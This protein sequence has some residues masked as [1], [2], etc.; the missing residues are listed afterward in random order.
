MM[1]NEDGASG[2]AS[3]APLPDSEIWMV[4]AGQRGVYADRFLDES[5]VA[6]GW[7]EIGEICADGSD[8]EIR[9]RFA[10]AF[11]NEKPGARAA[12]AGSVRRFVKEVRIGDEVVTYG[13]E[14]RLYRLGEIRS[15]VER[16]LIKVDG[17]ER[18]EFQRGVEWKS[19]VLRDSLLLDTRNRLGGLLTVF[20]V[21]TAA[22]VDLRRLSSQASGES[23]GATQDADDD[24]INTGDEVIDEETLIKEYIDK[25]EQFV[26]DAIMKLSWDELQELVAGVIRA[27]GYKTRVSSP[28]PDQGV[29][30]FAS[31]DGLGFAE[32]RI[33]V[34]VKHREGSISAPAIRSFIGGRQYGDRCLY[35]STGGFSREARVEAARAR[36]HLTLISRSDL[37]ELLVERYEA[38]D[39]ETRALVPLKKV[40][41]PVR[42]T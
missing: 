35:V 6:I 8:D 25:S 33:F 1:M 4:R 40:Y 10:E 19:Q 38:L 34:E 28:G 21:P 7:G 14:S 20:R 13:N 15:D 22:S 30:I 26:E 11:P 41:W 36:V 17:E 27:E 42:L 29:D 5:I 12:W 2:A 16:K 18:W 9:R 31:P 37:R 24:S 39:P 32:P 23:L 3:G